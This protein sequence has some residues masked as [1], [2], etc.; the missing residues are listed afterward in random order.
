MKENFGFEEESN[1]IRCSWLRVT[2]NPHLTGFCVEGATLLSEKPGAGAGFRQRSLQQLSGI[3]KK[4]VVIPALLH[5][6]SFILALPAFAVS[7]QFLGLAPSLFT[8]Y[9]DGDF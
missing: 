7:K 8:S 2:G 6:T 3:T 5:G 1:Y 9:K 4:P